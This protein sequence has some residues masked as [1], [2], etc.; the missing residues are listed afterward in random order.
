MS[1]LSTLE[2]SVVLFG[3]NGRGTAARYGEKNA[4][5]SVRVALLSTV[6]VFAPAEGFP[7]VVYIS[8]TRGVIRYDEYRGVAGRARARRGV[9]PGRRI[10]PSFSVY[11]SAA[12]FFIFRRC[13]MSPLEI[14]SR[15]TY[16]ASATCVRA[17]PSR[18]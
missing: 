17:A 10:E 16:M 13:S 15:C 2:V 3:V 1:S 12:S 7:R 4:G 5:M 18:E 11:L 8:P 6:G 14:T 9:S